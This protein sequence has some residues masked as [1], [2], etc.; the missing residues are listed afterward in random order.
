M[1]LF[2][3]LFGKKDFEVRTPGILGQSFGS[4]DNRTA[5]EEAARAL[6]NL[7]HERVVVKDKHGRTVADNWLGG[8]TPGILKGWR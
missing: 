2:D 3:D 5:A 6:S 8:T 4:T 7:T 1:G